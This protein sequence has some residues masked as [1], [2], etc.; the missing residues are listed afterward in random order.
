MG[1]PI[2]VIETN[3]KIGKFQPLNINLDEGSWWKGFES[4][5]SLGMQ[6]IKEGTDPVKHGFAF[7]LV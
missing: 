3:F 2:G 5:V 7:H 1:K 6:H 4:M